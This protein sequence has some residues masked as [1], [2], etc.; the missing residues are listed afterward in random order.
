MLGGLAQPATALRSHAACQFALAPALQHSLTE[1][2]VAKQHSKARK[3]LLSKRLTPSNR[4]CGA[5]HS[6]LLACFHAGSIETAT[7][8]WQ[9][10]N[11]DDARLI[12]LR[13]CAL[14][15][16]APGGRMAAPCSLQARGPRPKP[17]R[18]LGWPKS[19]LLGRSCSSFCSCCCCRCWTLL[20]ASAKHVAV[21]NTCRVHILHLALYRAILTKPTQP[22]AGMRRLG[23]S[24]D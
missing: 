12:I 2:Q 9:G 3:V 14:V 15:M 19:L 7:R 20:P 11:A 5:V 13:A 10:G 6:K 16:A 22:Q 23:S 21:C 8:G 18:P 1:R 24:C 4:V 17:C